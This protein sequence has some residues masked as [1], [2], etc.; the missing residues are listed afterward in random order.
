MLI[1]EWGSWRSCTK[2]RKQKPGLKQLWKV[3]SEEEMQVLGHALR[4][5]HLKDGFVRILKTVEGKGQSTGG[6]TSR[7]RAQDGSSGRLDL[8]LACF[9]TQ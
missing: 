2:G 1:V 5:L 9:S 3:F 4:G 8:V 7:I 6:G